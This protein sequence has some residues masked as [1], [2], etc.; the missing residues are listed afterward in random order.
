MVILRESKK[1]RERDLIRDYTRFGQA[2]FLY[3]PFAWI[4]SEHVRTAAPRVA[5]VSV[6]VCVYSRRCLCVCIVRLRVLTRGEN[7]KAFFQKS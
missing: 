4:Q 2:R 5:Y 7:G 1:R 3:L 6:F